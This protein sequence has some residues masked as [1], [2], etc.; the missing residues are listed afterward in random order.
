LGCD[1]QCAERVVLIRTV[2]WDIPLNRALTDELTANDL[3]VGWDVEAANVAID[4]LLAQR[5][6]M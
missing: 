1:R 4:R 5:E 3:P 2:I 6:R